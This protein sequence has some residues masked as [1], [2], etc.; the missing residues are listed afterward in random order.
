MEN[1]PCLSLSGKIEVA[2]RPHRF[3][4]LRSLVVVDW[5][6]ADA[7]RLYGS[8][9]RRSGHYWNSSERTAYDPEVDSGVV[10]NE[11]KVWFVFNGSNCWNCSHSCVCSQRYSKLNGQNSRL[12]ALS[13]RIDIAQ[14]CF[15]RYPFLRDEQTIMFYCKK[16]LVPFTNGA[17]TLAS[18]G[19]TVWLTSDDI[20]NNGLRHKHQFRNSPSLSLALA[21]FCLMANDSRLTSSIA[22]WFCGLCDDSVARYLLQFPKSP[23]LGLGSC[24]SRR[25]FINQSLL[26][27]EMCRTKCNENHGF[28]VCNM[29]ERLLFFVR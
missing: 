9:R 25:G 7:T 18:H 21:L 15:N 27:Y 2:D 4:Q 16:A 5:E 29:L 23:E 6:G 24:I 26:G 12:C 11:W 14:K 19:Q 17:S 10:S 28:F 8:S 22:E 13:C 1:F 20:V 3:W